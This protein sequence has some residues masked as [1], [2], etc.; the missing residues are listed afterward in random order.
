MAV[1]LNKYIVNYVLLFF[2]SVLE[3]KGHFLFFI[4]PIFTPNSATIA[5]VWLVLIVHACLER[6]VN[7]QV[8]TEAATMRRLTLEL[9]HSEKKTQNKNN[10]KQENVINFC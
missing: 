7:K 9:R 5:P 10:N 6:K 3:W 2:C 1:A 8:R 4:V